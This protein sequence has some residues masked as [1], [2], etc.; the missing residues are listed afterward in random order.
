VIKSSRGRTSGGTGGGRQ[1]IRPPVCYQRAGR[2]DS[3]RVGAVLE[4]SP[5][6]LTPLAFRD[7]FV[8]YNGVAVGFKQP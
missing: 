4:A 7:S 3:M 5:V 2:L 1:E 8:G 6:P